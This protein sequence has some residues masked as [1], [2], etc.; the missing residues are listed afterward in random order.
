MGSPVLP[1]P[2]RIP[3]W[4][5]STYVG[6]GLPRDNNHTYIGHNFP[7]NYGAI[8]VQGCDLMGS[9]LVQGCFQA[10]LANYMKCCMEYS[11]RVNSVVYT[12]G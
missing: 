9:R 12:T 5:A 3:R 8:A 6:L 4:L 10:I 7:I 1:K 11:I 2:K